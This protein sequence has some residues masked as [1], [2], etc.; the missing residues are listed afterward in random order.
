V[1]CREELTV[2]VRESEISAPL[3]R[4]GCYWEDNI[5]IDH[6]KLDG[7]DLTG[8]FWFRRGISSG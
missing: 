6:S 2:L 4:P 5:K 3:G 1:I 8:G 7:R